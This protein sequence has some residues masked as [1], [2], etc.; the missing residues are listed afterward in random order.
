MSSIVFAAD[1]RT[2]AGA[3]GSF[4][5][6]AITAIASMA[7]LRAS[8]ARSSVVSGSSLVMDGKMAAVI[9]WINRSVRRVE[10]NKKG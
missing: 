2:F 10:N 6:S 1:S 7:W 8:A 9:G 3:P 5:I 4:M